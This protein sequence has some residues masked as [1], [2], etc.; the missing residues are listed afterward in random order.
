MRTAL[1]L[2]IALLFVAPA[3]GDRPK[4]AEIALRDGA[5]SVEGRLRGRGQRTYAVTAAAGQTLTLEMSAEPMRSVALE[6]YD[7]DGLRLLLQKE[8]A[9]RWTTP[10]HKSGAYSL[11]VVRST[12]TAP[13]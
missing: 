4:P 6:V 5:G 12:P 2:L 1:R 9:G 7:P 3:L 8:A 13:T 11:T 10:A